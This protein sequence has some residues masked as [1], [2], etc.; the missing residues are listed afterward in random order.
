M[1]EQ[2][3][4]IRRKVIVEK[5]KLKRE[6]GVPALFSAGYGNVG[7]SIYYAIGATAFFALG[8]SPIVIALAGLFFILTAWTFSEGATMMP[9]SG[10]VSHFARKAFNESFSFFAAWVHLLTYIVTVAI[11]VY[12]AA[13]YMKAF[14]GFVEKPI[15]ISIGEVSFSTDPHV[16]AII[17][18][19]VFITALM[20]LNVKGVKEAASFNIFFA[21]VDILTQLLLI[22]IGAI[23]MLNLGKFVEYYNAGAGYWPSDWTAWVQGFAVAMI[24]YTGVGT[25][26][27][28]SEETADY[29]KKI[30]S[31]Y[32]W[33]IIAVLV[34]SV[35]LPM[36]VNSAVPPPEL[37][38]EKEDAIAAFA[39]R[40]PEL[41][42]FGAVIPL[43]NIFVPWVSI[44]AVTI[45]LMAANAGIMG[46][47]R[48]AY[49]MGEHRH[50]PSFV[51]K[52]HRKFNTPHIGIIIISIVAGLLLLS[53]LIE[54]GIFVKLAKLYAFSSMLIFAIAHLSVIWLRIKAPDM[55]RPWKM[56]FNVKIK[57]KEIPVTA[58][59]GILI[60]IFV[61]LVIVFGEPWTRAVGLVWVAAGFAMYIYY[62]VKNK[63]PVHEEVTIERVVE[64]AYQPINYAGIIVPTTGELEAATMQTACKIALRDKSRILAMYVIEVPM[65]LPVDASIPT[66]KEKG[67]KALDQAEMVAKEYGVSVET[68]LVQARS[69][70]K[71]IVEEAEKRNADLVLLGPTGKTKSTEIL[72]GKTVSYVSKNAPC[73]VLMNIS[74]QV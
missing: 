12:T 58:V 41:T 28:M 36:V 44:L 21:A 26:S 4:S 16:S 73:R 66:K 60:N 55:E 35:S 59:I 6:L 62:R 49:S 48:L 3:R 17:I 5:E 14:V 50:L 24:A 74:E 33:L 61:W 15:P 47:S 23:F 13:E 25:I 52:L 43:K 70:G 54:E 31:A 2:L 64:T 63:L 39:R 57:G 22:I 30:P 72:A 8:A 51:F 34:M 53:G 9:Y 68:K 7:S 27:Q 40:M 10:G 11:S 37:V 19:L 71:A 29:K 69:A 1:P 32:F 38:A 46:A 45:L 65:T 18:A 56:K 42:V 20:Y 67:E